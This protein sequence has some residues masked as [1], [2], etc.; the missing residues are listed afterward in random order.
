MPTLQ[1]CEQEVRR[2]H[3]FFV[4]WYTGRIGRDA[5]YRVDDALG[6]DF[7]MVTPDGTLHERSDVVEM[8]R[9]SYGRND[10]DEFDIEIRNVERRSG[11][12]DHATV[13]YEEWQTTP[14]G[15]SGR[16]S[17]ALLRDDEDTPGGICWLDLHETWL[18]AE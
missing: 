17:T 12:T 6:A 14:D 18:E 10:P 16:I 9:S 11:F 7:R 1:D 4:E 15:T 2:L 13:R 8:V 5:F 3:E